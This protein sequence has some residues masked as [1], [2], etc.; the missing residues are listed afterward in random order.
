MTD[1]TMSRTTVVV[2][3]HNRIEELEQSLAKLGQLPE[4][5][6]VIV[7]DNGS[8]PAVPRSVVEPHPRWRLIRLPVNEGAAARNVGVATATTPYVAFNDDDTW[9]A[10]GSLV[11]AADFLDA[12]PTVAV[13]NAHITVEPAGTEDPICVELRETPL[14]VDGLPGHVLGSFLAGASVVRRSAFVDIGGFERRL[15]IGGEEEL[16][17]MDLRAAGWH[18]V[19]LPDITIH[20]RPSPSRDPSLR[21]RQGI[22][23]HLWLILLR[24]PWRSVAGRCVSL[25]RRSPNDLHTWRAV[26]DAI[27]G[28]PWVLR[29]R[30][31]LPA[32]VEADQRLLD[33][34]QDRSEARRYIG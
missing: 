19:H 12:E 29:R 27:L 14:H 8:H 5:P 18:L 9:W 24:R 1:N 3:T 23:N 26:G 4:R 33:R 11:R 15:L 34:A 30:R 25:I 16:L 20:H 10:A 2:I 31:C 28:L 22:R 7:V 6:P 13:L 17:A 32:V 21:R